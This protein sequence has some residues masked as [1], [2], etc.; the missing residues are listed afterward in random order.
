MPD[1]A[2]K[3]RTILGLKFEHLI[4]RWFVQNSSHS[5]SVSVLGQ[6]DFLLSPIS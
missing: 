2:G 1:Q 5:A 4:V 3:G 6:M